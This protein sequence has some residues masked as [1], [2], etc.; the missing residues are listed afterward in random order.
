MAK[1]ILI[2]GIDQWH[3][4]FYKVRCFVSTTHWHDLGAF[5]DRQKAI[6][7]MRE[8]AE[9]NRYEVMIPESKTDRK[10]VEQD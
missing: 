7:Y 1:I 4:E 2:E 10:T 6:D 5:R 8:L 9:Q 3:K